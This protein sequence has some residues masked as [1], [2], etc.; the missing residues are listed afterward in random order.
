ML[1]GLYLIA[2]VGTR[3]AEKAGVVRCGC[4]DDCWCKQPLLAAFRW[5]FPCRHRSHDHEPTHVS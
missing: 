5:V 2:A 4:A 3:A 1:I